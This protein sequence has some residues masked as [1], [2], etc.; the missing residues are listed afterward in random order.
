MVEKWHVNREGV[1][2]I[3]KAKI[4]CRF[5][6][7]ETGHYP[8]KEEAIE[9]F[10]NSMAGK[11]F[12]KLHKEE[13]KE[14]DN[15]PIEE[16]SPRKG[17]EQPKFSTETNHE[18]EPQLVEKPVVEEDFSG[19]K[20]LNPYLRQ[21]S[22]IVN[23]EEYKW[24]VYHDL[25]KESRSHLP[26]YQP[27]KI[28]KG[29]LT[30]GDRVHLATIS[31]DKDELRKFSKDKSE[32]V[33]ICVASNKN[34]SEE[35]L[36]YLYQENKDSVPILRAIAENNNSPDKLRVLLA[37]SENNL[38]RS[39]AA[40]FSGLPSKRI[41][42]LS[43]DKSPEVRMGIAKNPSTPENVLLELAQEKS[44]MILDGLSDNPNLSKSIIERAKKTLDTR[45]TPE[46]QIGS[47][48]MI[49]KKLDRK[50]KLILQS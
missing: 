29:S 32:K 27:P 42:E 31:K 43:K 26:T 33:R 9:G 14:P 13:N 44:I 22:E 28:K 25:N 20:F 35:T 47:V 19:R 41:V 11:E 45:I 38:V 7:M 5:G 24:E 15:I 40:S 17:W 10:E 50:L 49:S 23:K 1:P 16:T 6:N 48:N 18:Q 3:C 21:N 8:S 46:T 39:S 12:K 2:G 30:V 37:N 34:S 4:F 36:I